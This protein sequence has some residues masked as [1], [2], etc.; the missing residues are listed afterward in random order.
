MA[1]IKNA[2]GRR[3]NQSPSGYTRLFGNEDLGNLMSR[4]QAA[5]ISSGSELE[6]LILEKSHSIDDFDKFISDINYKN[7]GIYVASKKQI[8]SSKIIKTSFEPDLIAFDLVKRIC[9]VIEVKDGDQFDTKKA[10]GERANLE[11]FVNYASPKL[12]FSFKAYVCSFNSPNKESILVGLKHK[13]TIDE[14]ITGRESCDLLGIDFDDI[15]KVRNTDQ[16][17]NLDYFIEELVEIPEVH[18]RLIQKL[19]D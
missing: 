6:K 19:C 7:S 16:T 4:V 11:S 1:L 12:P 17:A 13:F 14:V 3:K 2:K 10:A 18:Q 15:N 8:K 9:Y 5:V